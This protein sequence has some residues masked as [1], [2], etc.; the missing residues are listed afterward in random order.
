MLD[1]ASVSPDQL[2]VLLTQSLVLK[3]LYGDIP[4]LSDQSLQKLQVLSVLL[5][6]EREGGKSLS[7]GLREAVEPGPK[8]RLRLHIAPV[9][10]GHRIISPHL[11]DSLLRVEYGIVL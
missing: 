9:I 5:R 6:E 10:Q 2:I 1:I 3:L 7:A 4:K 11:R 8:L